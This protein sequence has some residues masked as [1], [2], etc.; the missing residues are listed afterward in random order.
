M[1]RPDTSVMLVGALASAWVAFCIALHFWYGL[2]GFI[3][4]IMP[5]VFDVIHRLRTGKDFE[6]LMHKDS[7]AN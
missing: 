2:L 7:D 4:G 1:R 6:F 5:V 3:A